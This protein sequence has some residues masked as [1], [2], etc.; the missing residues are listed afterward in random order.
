MSSLDHESN[1]F[2]LIQFLL[3]NIMTLV[4]FYVFFFPTGTSVWRC[5][6]LQLAV[7]FLTLFMVIWIFFERRLLNGNF[8]FAVTFS[9]QSFLF[10]TLFRVTLASLGIFS[11][12]ICFDA[13]P[14]YFLRRGTRP[15]PYN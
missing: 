9:C 13:A 3:S 15:T 5:S 6:W 1:N 2:S 8:N 14:F 12:L 7:D 11:L 4:L 10:S